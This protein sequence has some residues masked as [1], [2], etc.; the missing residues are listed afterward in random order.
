MV[1][2]APGTVIILKPDDV[3]YGEAMGRLRDWLDANQIEPVVFTSHAQ[4]ERHAVV[5]GDLQLA[6]IGGRVIIY[7][8]RPIGGDLRSAG[9]QGAGEPPSPGWRICL[10]PVEGRLC[11]GSSVSERE[12]LRTRWSIVAISRM[13]RLST[14]AAAFLIVRSG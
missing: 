13:C 8:D 6:R 7:R 2:T 10:K 14:S 4:P 1:I 12:C 3:S 9:G 5:S 11:S